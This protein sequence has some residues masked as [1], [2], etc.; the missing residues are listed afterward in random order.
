[1]N[2]FDSK[3]FLNQMFDDKLPLLFYWHFRFCSKIVITN[4]VLAILFLL[5]ESYCSIEV[6]NWL[7]LNCTRVMI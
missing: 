6:M 7:L 5:L 3:N 4:T 2:T 1:M